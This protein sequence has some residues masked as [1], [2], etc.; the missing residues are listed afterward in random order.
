[1]ARK[2]VR[3]FS[4]KSVERRMRD[5]MSRQMTYVVHSSENEIPPHL[6]E[7]NNLILRERD[8]RNLHRDA[9]HA[10]SPISAKEAGMGAQYRHVYR[11]D[12]SSMDPVVRGDE[13]RR[14][15]SQSMLD[16]SSPHVP[17]PQ[18]FED[19]PL[20][21]NDIEDNLAQE[22]PK[23]QPY[24]N[25]IEDS[26]SLSYIIPRN[27]VGKGVTYLGGGKLDAQ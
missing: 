1:M 18:L 15:S 14:P 17:T 21:F 7:N 3:P 11:I 10:G 22:N 9:F 19:V 5:H 23:V 27:I 26:G 20:L 25:D 12:R 16:W 4:V 2:G 8:Y 13:H 6:A 24:R